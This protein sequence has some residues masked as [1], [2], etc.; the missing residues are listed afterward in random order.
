MKRSD[1]EPAGSA[2][3]RAI[4]TG[5][6]FATVPE[7]ARWAETDPRSIRRGIEAGE[8]PATR[9]GS[10]VRVPMSWVKAQLD[11]MDTTA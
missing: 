4:D 1:E 11:L 2:L 3:A 8:I 7:L 9:F 6:L 5:R 10:V